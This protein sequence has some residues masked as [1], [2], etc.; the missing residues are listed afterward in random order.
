MSDLLA[1]QSGTS[2]D[3]E[4]FSF[5]MEDLTR[6]ELR[7]LEVIEEAELGEQIG[8]KDNGWTIVPGSWKGRKDIAIGWVPVRAKALELVRQREALGSR[9]MFAQMSLM[10]S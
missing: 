7:L 2:V 6:L 8:G 1:S 4:I 10:S 3:T 5:V 9:V